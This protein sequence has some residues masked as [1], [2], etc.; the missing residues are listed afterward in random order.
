[1]TLTEFKRMINFVGIVDIHCSLVL[2]TKKQYMDIIVGI[3][4]ISS[5][6]VS[7][8][9]AETLI[10]NAS[11][12]EIDGEAYLRNPKKNNAWQN[13]KAIDY[14][15]EG[16]ENTYARYGDSWILNKSEITIIY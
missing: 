13:K 11:F 8:K 6:Y 15:A 12:I 7:M 3:A 4:K 1:M 16:G 2:N 10:K 14:V 5:V 9:D